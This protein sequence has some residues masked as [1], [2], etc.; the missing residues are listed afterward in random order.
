MNDAVPFSGA[1]AADV[2]GNISALC[3]CTLE[4]FQGCFM[5]LSFQLEAALAPRYSCTFRHARET[6]ED[7]HA[8]VHYLDHA[9]PCYMGAG[10]A[11]TSR[12]SLILGWCQDCT[13][14]C[15]PDCCVDCCCSR[16]AAACGGIRAVL[17]S[18]SNAAGGGKFW[19]RQGWKPVS[20]TW[21]NQLDDYA[22]RDA[23]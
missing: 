14:C 8:V 3:T 7:T 2:I 5:R 12:C 17:R 19:D 13:L 16:L 23:S 6:A 20:Q 18:I 21:G 22:R 1:C 4:L 11:S 10:L 9:P 15:L